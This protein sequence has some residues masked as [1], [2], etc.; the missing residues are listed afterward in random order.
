ML[1]RAVFGSV[2]EP[3]HRLANCS[4]CLSI[5]LFDPSLEAFLAPLC[6]LIEHEEHRVFVSDSTELVTFLWA[7]LKAC[8]TPV[9]VVRPWGRGH[10]V[11]W[12]A[13]GV[14]LA[15]PTRPLR[16]PV[17]TVLDM[18]RLWLCRSGRHAC[19]RPAV[20]QGA[21]DHRCPTHC[22]R[23]PSLPRTAALLLCRCRLIALCRD[24]S[25][26]R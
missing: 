7:L 19:C 13:L 11:C 12:S 21:V 8:T 24:D 6:S 25:P 10:Q 16:W 23:L 17:E 4:W 5:S 3:A 1:E 26:C 2:C 15:P 22:T 9:S 18:A 20:G 14:P